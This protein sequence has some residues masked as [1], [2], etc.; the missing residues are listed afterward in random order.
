M[1]REE[2]TSAIR[3]DTGSLG[4]ELRPVSAWMCSFALSTTM[5]AGTDK[6]DFTLP[7]SRRM[8]NPIRRVL[9]A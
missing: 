9:A 1:T 5:P 4:L 6:A 3:L 2:A 8:V 7:K